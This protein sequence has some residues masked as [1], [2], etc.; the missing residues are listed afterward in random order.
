MNDV[1]PGEGYIKGFDGLRAIA[2]ALVI[3]I[4]LGAYRGKYVALETWAD[5]VAIFF[6]LSG[7][8]ITGILLND[9]QRRIP[10][11]FLRRMIRLYPALI[12]YLA[13]VVLFGRIG[14]ASVP[15]A[16][17]ATGT[18][19]VSNFATFTAQARETSHLWSLAVEEQFYLIWPFVIFYLR[20]LAIPIAVA[21][22]V[23]SWYLR[24]Y[25]PV[26][27]TRYVDRYFIPAAD[28]ILI[29]CVAALIVCPRFR[30]SERIR[31]RVAAP[32]MLLAAAVLFFARQCFPV[33]PFIGARP[34]AYLLLELQ[35]VG[36]ALGVLWIC[37][38]Q[39]ST[40]VRALNWLP[41]RYLGR[42]SYGIY[43]WQ[44]L[45]VRNGSS[46]PA[47]WFDRFPFNVV[48]AVAMAALSFELVER[49]FLRLKNRGSQS[50]A[51]H[52]KLMPGEGHVPARVLEDRRGDRV[53]AQEGDRDRD[54][55]FA[56]TPGASQ[57]VV[58]PTRSD[59]HCQ[60]GGCRCRERH[61]VGDCV[62]TTEAGRD[63]DGV[64]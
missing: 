50:E 5:G 62:Q 14:W 47:G 61:L 35:R 46:D 63:G 19:Y 52:S 27:L 51:V 13:A 6:V 43:L 57:R 20:R 36:I 44:G 29:G 59:P 45:F 33:L 4:H 55:A 30:M 60:S 1:M 42:I 10:R 48:L 23:A 54:H 40:L 17:V 11:F 28:S 41:L 26:D 21:G 12:L 24:S 32:E 7:F 31:E 3:S 9:K 16:A 56:H 49:R 64:A 53:R 18:L 15:A 22:V 25:P 37:G 38:N 34:G 39:G 58:L 2:V 8:L